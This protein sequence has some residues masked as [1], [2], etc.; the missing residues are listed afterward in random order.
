MADPNGMPTEENRNCI[1]A[2]D[3]SVLRLHVATLADDAGLASTLVAAD[4]SALTRKN[5]A[6]RD[7]LHV[8][9]SRGSADV[10]D[11][12]LALQADPNSRCG[13]QWTPLHLA[14]SNNHER[15]VVA[16]LERRS[17]IN[18]VDSS[19]CTPLWRAVQKSS[20]E[21]AM[22]LMERNA[23]VLIPDVDGETPLWQACEKG[24]LSL[25]T[26]MLEREAD[27]NACD[28][29]LHNTPLHQACYGGHVEAV[30]ALLR[31]PVIQVNALNKEQS[32]PLH[33]ACM[34]GHIEV[35]DVLLRAG[36]D[37]FLR[38]SSERSPGAEAENQREGEYRACADACANAC[39]DAHGA[40][41]CACVQR[42]RG[43]ISWAMFLGDGVMSPTMSRS[44]PPFPCA[45]TMTDMESVGL[46][47][48]VVEILI[49]SDHKILL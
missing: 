11:A 15:I 26:A 9:C 1:Y 34:K 20:S 36:A 19:S 13:H 22:V 47:I 24:A 3:D 21:A 31:M 12:L 28:D 37:A 43:A 30:V 42:Q 44:H 48:G 14:A 2:T 25:V 7:A 4:S 27:V 16:L 5:K 49:G 41:A 45:T 39:A 18:A 8:A 6:F 35:V 46:W 17:A 33:H 40:Y 38:N 32:S 10:A 29:D 23:D